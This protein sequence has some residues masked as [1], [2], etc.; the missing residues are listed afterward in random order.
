M[1][2]F[3]VKVESHPIL[4]RLQHLLADLLIEPRRAVQSFG[5]VAMDIRSGIPSTDRRQPW[6]IRCVHMIDVAA[7]AKPLVGNWQVRAATYYPAGGGM[8]WHTDSGRP[9]WR[10]YVVLPLGRSRFLT[11]DQEFRDMGGTA[12]VFKAGPGA[13]HAVEAT[14]ERFSIGVKVPDDVAA[15]LAAVQV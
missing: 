6:S 14:D 5:D 13:W 15:E 9:G 10:V 11:V 8:G 7:R 3:R 12:M 4:E 1:E 2:A